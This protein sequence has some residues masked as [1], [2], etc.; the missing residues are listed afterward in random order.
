MILRSDLPGDTSTSPG[1]TCCCLLERQHVN[2]LGFYINV[3]HEQFVINM[4]CLYR[5]IYFL[6]NLDNRLDVKNMVTP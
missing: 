6:N 4:F 5:F 3:P 1:L 2:Q